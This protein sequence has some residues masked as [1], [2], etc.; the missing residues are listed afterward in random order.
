MF[1]FT[2][3]REAVKQ[4]IRNYR[5]L[6]IYMTFDFPAGTDAQTAE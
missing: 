6:N 1:V 4:T 2:I 3:F 5:L